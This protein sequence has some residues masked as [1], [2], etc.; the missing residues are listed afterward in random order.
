MT[1]MPHE[2]HKLRQEKHETGIETRAH[3][4]AG[5]HSQQDV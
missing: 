5:A 2:K 1:E 3:G 4:W